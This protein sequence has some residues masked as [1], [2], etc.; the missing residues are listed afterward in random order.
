MAVPAQEL[1]PDDDDTLHSGVYLSNG[2]ESL[3]TGEISDAITSFDQALQRAVDPYSRA[4]LRYQRA[5]AFERTGRYWG[6]CP[7]V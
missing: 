2:M 4:Y 7:G 3:D 6:G 5:Q 1:I